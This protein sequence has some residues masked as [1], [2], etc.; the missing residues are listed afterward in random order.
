MFPVFGILIDMPSMTT[1]ISG[2]AEWSG[3]L[4]SELWS[5]FVPVLGLLFVGYI[6]SLF[7]GIFK[8]KILSKK[9]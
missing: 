9:D 6:I 5:Y 7:Y 2:M 1:T 8:D 4:F 3:P